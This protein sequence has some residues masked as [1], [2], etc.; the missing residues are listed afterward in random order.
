MAKKTLTTVDAVRM[1]TAEYVA[2]IHELLEHA[3]DAAPV[4]PVVEAA[5]KLSPKRK[6]TKKEIA[7]HMA[8]MRA[9]RDAKR[10][11]ANPPAVAAARKAKAQSKA[12]QERESR[13]NAGW[14]VREFKTDR[15]RVPAKLSPRLRAVLQFLIA[16]NGKTVADARIAKK[17][18]L[19][20]AAVR[21]ALWH[22]RKQ[23]LAEMV[24]EQ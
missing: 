13:A 17:L 16:A 20:V 4:A 8:K 18:D 15:K 14:A 24:E 23:D 10:A 3:P 2:R 1:A 19:S 21:T 12:Q 11:A 22:L 7:A 9:A 6:R 5:P